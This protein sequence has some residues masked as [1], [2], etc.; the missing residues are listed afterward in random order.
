M[1]IRSIYAN[2][3]APAPT[4]SI[5]AQDPLGR[6]PP[7]PTSRSSGPARQSSALANLEKTATTQSH[8]G[9]RGG[10]PASPGTVGA[11]VRDAAPF[12]KLAGSHLA[13]KIGLVAPTL[14]GIIA[15]IEQSAEL[16]DWQRVPAL[17]ATRYKEARDVQRDVGKIVKHLKTADPG[18][19]YVY[20]N[21]DTKTIWAVL[22]DSDDEQTHQRWYNALKAISG[23][24]NVRTE[25]EYGPHGD[26]DWV[27]IK[28]AAAA[29]WLGAPYRLAGKLT[30]GASP[31]SNTIVNTLLGAGT[32]YGLGFLAENLLPEEYVERGKLRRNLAMLGGGAG[33]LPGA[34]QAH[35]NNRISQTA[36]K[37]MGMSAIW[38]PDSKVPL[39][40]HEATWKNSLNAGRMEKSF[41]D[42]MSQLPQIDAM[43]QRANADFIKLAFGQG[44]YGTNGVPYTA[45]PVDAFNNA[46]WN[47]VHKGLQSSQNNAFGTRSPYGANQDTFHTPPAVGA[48]V[49]GLVSGVQQQY[50]GAPLLSPKHF[51]TGLAGAGVDLATAR[52]AGGVLGALGGLTPKAQQTLQNMGL[53]GGFMR[54]VS[55]S[56]LGL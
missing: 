27:R 19:G 15:R 16:A 53:W 21:P 45:I 18:Y 11:R 24:R 39:S 7:H 29:S 8:R 41:A 28:S 32:G 34:M 23:V 4:S 1:T 9:S 46:V 17:V 56:V 51:V 35:L 2:E 54:G 12:T 37:P 14:P 42:K 30:G 55:K 36:G 10:P 40:P 50:G 25:S 47:D 38:K 6:R 5:P 52:V 3:S 31:L 26:S 43:L 49:T 13:L 20:W 44:M 22:S 48:A 33:L